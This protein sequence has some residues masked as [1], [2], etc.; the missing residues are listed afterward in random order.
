MPK[1]NRQILL[2]VPIIDQNKATK[3]LAA[4]GKELQ[5]IDLTWS[6]RTCAI[7]ALKSI[8]VYQNSQLSRVPIMRL[9]EQGQKLQGFDDTYGWRHKALLQLAQLNGQNL[10]RLFAKTIPYRRRGLR[11][12]SKNI[13]AGRPVIASIFYRLDKNRGGHMV[14]IRGITWDAKGNVLTYHVMDP[15]HIFQGNI[16]SLSRSE[17]VEHWRGG[18]IY[19]VK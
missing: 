2:K 17:F 4:N 8:L 18:L 13:R 12:I 10:Y 14:V 11:I 7:C 5:K 3:S 16:Y 1:N 6:R 15:D 9:V 19:F